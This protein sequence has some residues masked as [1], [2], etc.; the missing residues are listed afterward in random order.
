MIVAVIGANG[1]SGKQFTKA[2]LAA[3]M[4]VRAGVRGPHDLEEHDSMTIVA[5]DALSRHEIDNLVRGSDA[6][7]SLIGHGPGVSATVQKTAT[8]YTLAAMK[9]H[10]VR[11]FI[12]LT[13][14]GVRMPG[15]K[16]GLIDKLGNW[17]MMQADPERVRDGIA[18]AEVM[19]Q[20]SSDWT[21]L[22]VLKLTNGT[23]NGQPVLAANVPSELF[24]PRARVAAAIVRLL[25]GN[26]YVRQAPVI[27]G[28]DKI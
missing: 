27:R 18:H 14:T 23:H 21:L 19:M 5:C 24:T 20:S 7:V 17:W 28:T 2:A 4:T 8:L 3:G 15:D 22:R 16:P 9:E 11:R 26:E 10:G 13:G 25:Q 1:R 6:V 12:S